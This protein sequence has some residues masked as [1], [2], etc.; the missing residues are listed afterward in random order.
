[1]NGV[2]KKETLDKDAL[3]QVQGRN[4]LRKLPNNSW[5]CPWP[6]LVH[7]GEN[8]LSKASHRKCFIANL[9]T[10]ASKH[11]TWGFSPD[12]ENKK[13]VRTSWMCR[14][15][16]AP[17]AVRLPLRWRRRSEVERARGTTA[18]QGR[19]DALDRLMQMS[20]LLGLGYTHNPYHH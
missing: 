7:H 6:W 12:H 17:G 19:L 4:V 18:A 1:M 5:H 20:L 11:K 3:T 14:V 10:S 9:R 15:W 13:D 2:E 16:V 8:N